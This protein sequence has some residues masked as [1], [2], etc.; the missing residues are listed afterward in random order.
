MGSVR[1]IQGKVVLVEHLKCRALRHAFDGHVLREKVQ[2]KIRWVARL[3]CD[4]CGTLRIDVMMP[5]TC[6]L[7]SRRYDHP[8]NYDGTLSQQAARR[9]LFKRMLAAA[10]AS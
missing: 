10:A 9:E 4:R 1:S 5:N 8:D 7:V 2:G 6:E 3:E